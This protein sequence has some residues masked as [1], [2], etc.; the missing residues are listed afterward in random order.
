MRAALAL[1]ALAAAYVATGAIDSTVRT[2]PYY[3]AT[4]PQRAGFRSPAYDWS[5]VDAVL[6][7]AIASSVFPGCV[8]AVRDA[9]GSLVLVEGVG[10]Y[11]YGEP[12]PGPAAA[13]TTPG[14]SSTGIGYSASPPMTPDTAFDMASLTKIVGPTT[15]AAYLYQEGYL[16]LDWPVASPALLGPAFAGQGKAN[17]T[18]ANL[19][20]HNAGFPPDP[21]PGYWEPDF[22]CPA[23]NQTHPPLT[24]SCSELIYGA[25][26]NQML[27]APVGSI[28]VYSDLSMITLMYAVGNLIQAHPG[29]VQEGW[30][31]PSCTTP[32]VHPGLTAMCYYQAF[33]AH[34]ILPALG[35][36]ATTYLPPVAS[37][38]NTA[39]TWNDTYYRNELLQ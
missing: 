14:E 7:G 28:Y 21:V 26:L 30:L 3:S 38:G 9:T 32:G 34:V 18:V 11:T 2:G 33:H 1:A 31:Y 4:G 13:S 12:V 5:A 20:L 22:G 37:Y 10:N 29:W 35:M 36:A 25:V 17:I 8:A 27:A 23:T 16:S 15:V 24:F 6:N 39:P 19:L